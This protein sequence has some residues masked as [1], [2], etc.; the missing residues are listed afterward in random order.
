MVIADNEIDSGALL[1][2]CYPLSFAVSD[3]ITPRPKRRIRYQGTHPRAFAQKYKEQQPDRY[4]ADVEKVLASG[5]TP[6]GMH[7][8]IMVDEILSALQPRPG[9]TALDCTL[10]YGGHARALLDR[11]QPGGRMIGLDTDPIE[12]PKTE[13]RLRALG[14][15]EAMLSVRRMNFAGAVQLIGTEAPRGFDLILADLGVSSMQMDDPARGFTF[16][17]EGPLDLRMNPNRGHP[18]SELLART[19]VEELEEILRE[20]SDE[21]RAPQIARA[22]VE[23]R[24][25]RPITTT[26]ELSELVRKAA[27]GPHSDDSV[28]RVFQ[29]I[30][31][32]VNEE[33]SALETFL[34]HLPSCLAPGG[35][36]AILSFHSGEDRRV[37]HAFKEGARTG[38]YQSISE[39]VGRPTREEIRANPRSSSAKL[40]WA[41]QC[42]S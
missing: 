21:P 13:S 8:P 24:Q 11:I 40:R 27:P 1:P 34:R 41:M 42:P 29:A 16:K 20:N 38:L 39:E 10:G 36:V 33:L 32:A 12:L 26:T 6:A 7:R 35:R 23:Y 18:G 15:D 9:M 22:I 30:R 25:R 3:E 14:Y 4:G 19:P 17:H 2:F 31:I 5:K 37:K 28:R